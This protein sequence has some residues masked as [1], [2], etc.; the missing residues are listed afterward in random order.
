M[1]QIPPELVALLGYL[2]PH[3]QQTLFVIW[4]NAKNEESFI[5]EL[6]RHPD[7]LEALQNAGSSDL[8]DDALAGLAEILEELERPARSQEE[9]AYRVELCGRALALVEREQEPALWAGLHYKMAVGLA[10]SSLGTRAMNLEQ[11]IVHF[12]KALEIFTRQAYPA[13]WALTQKDLGNAYLQRIRGERV[14]N[15]EQAICHYRQSL[16]V[17]TR[18]ADPG[19]WAMTQ[20][21]LAAAYGQRICGERAENLEQAI[22]HAQEAL[23]VRTRQA[24]PVSW[25][26]TQNNLGNAYRERIRGERAENLE[27][28]IA[29]Y[30][31]ALEV[32]TRQADPVSWAQT[33]NNLGN[34]YRERIRG[35]PAEN[36][37]QAIAHYHQALEVYT[38][39]ADPV[40][41][42]QTQNSLG[43]AYHERIRGER[44]ENLE[45]AITYHNQALE[46][47]TRQAD[48]V[49]W[50]QTQNSLG[51]AYRERIRGERAENLEQAIAH[52]E[53]A[54][55]VLTRQADPVSW[56]KTHSNLA[57]AYG[58]R[59]RGERAENLDQAIIHIQHAL[60]VL[61]R[62]ADPVSWALAQNNLG[63]ACSERIHGE[64]AENLEQAIAHYRQALEVRTRQADPVSW[65]QTQN[66]L[67]TAYSERICGERAENLELAIAHCRQALEVYT[68][69]SD[70][71]NWAMNQ[72]SLAAVYSVRIRGEGAQNLEQAISHYQ[73]ALQVDTRQANPAGWAMAQNNLALAYIK[74]ISGK[75]ADNLEEAIAYCRQ[76]L[77]VFTQR[78][79]PARWG[80]TQ[81]CL[82]FAYSERIYG[83]RAQNLEKAI[84]HS[85]KAL[86]VRTLAQFPADFQLTQRNLA[87]LH[88]SEGRWAEALSA[89]QEAIAAE[90]VLLAGAYTETGRQAEVDKTSKMYVLAAYALLMLGRPAEALVQ[91]EEGKTRLLSKALALN[92]L[93]LNGLPEA[94]QQQLHTLRQTIRALEAEMRLPPETPARRDERELAEALR[95]ARGDLT[96]A[97]EAVRTSHPDFMPEGLGLAEILALIPKEAAL[98]APLITSQ[99]SAVFVIPGG[100]TSVSSEHVLW[101]DEFKG[102]DLRALLQGA[103]EQ[104]QLGGWLGAYFNAHTNRKAWLD[105]ID[106]AGK[107]LWERLM[108]LVTERLTALHVRRVLLMHQGG[109]GLLP[110]HA[111]WRESN[112]RRRY[113]LDD[114]TV[115]LVPSAYAR[116]VG[117]DR[118]DEALRQGRTLFAVVNPTDDLP[119]TPAEGEQVAC[120]FGENNATIL[121]GAKATAAAVK[122]ADAGYLHFACHGF[123]YWQ[124]PMQS[125]LILAQ[126][127]PFTLG[128]VI[129][130]LNLESTRLVTLSACETGITDIRQSPDEYLGLPAGFLQAGAP[131]V[132]STLWAVNDL[133][134]MLLMERF[135]QLHLEE[136]KVIPEALCQAQIW[137]RDVTAGQ[138]A[139]RFA[140]EEEA[141]LASTRMSIEAASKFY[142]QFKTLNPEHRPFAHPYYWAAFTFS[143]V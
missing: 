5:R 45:Q 64:R 29:H 17:F 100:Q 30:H 18:K 99:G 42:A 134:T 119:F 140:G 24:D 66:N 63:N 57:T 49:S 11:A 115:T 68:R 120:L 121:S 91:L 61:T 84:A 118:L 54:L 35:E 21:N 27:Q 128:Q 46:V 12:D 59:I 85:Q 65:A 79:D 136:G 15:L 19:T 26:E 117:Q 47:Y 80:V 31:Q 101:L 123:Y 8:E 105:S 62:Q 104:A 137:L 60:E 14:E 103:S 124:E 106:A 108:T 109:L 142:V 110:L 86:E 143:G 52:Y 32:R 53:H 67:G 97:I 50:A 1:E 34:A 55:E 74:R 107:V 88:F 3:Q 135:Y 95:Q 25:A 36:L 139:E 51:N 13:N 89:C 98:V 111:A 102:A 126:G 129:G 138:L 81:Y 141:L 69:Q 39:Q 83:E 125:G 130:H 87:N 56:A 9:M 6:Q 114:Y 44:V 132:V 122:E 78:A 96:V 4:Q 72:N 28:A 116:R 38:R 22:T 73:N 48:P 131:A 7:L 92:E 76:A 43:N 2:T 20:N 33:Q 133:S 112:G 40:S 16:E 58:E 75:R 93:D 10:Q 90:R 77:E 94:Q 23:E 37:E 71:A 82:A 70:P 127:E 113:F 41:W